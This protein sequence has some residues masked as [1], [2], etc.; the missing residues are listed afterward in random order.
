[1]SRRWLEVGVILPLLGLL[2]LIARAELQLRSGVSF[3]VPIEGYDPRD[4]LH[5][6]FLQYRFSFDW[7]G[8]NRCGRLSGGVPVEVDPA[9]CICLS[10]GT[11]AGH[12]PARQ[13][14][15][16]EVARCD[17]WLRGSALAPPLKYFVPERRALELEEA[18]RGRAAALDVTCGPDGQPAIGEL[19]LDG[20]PWRDV[21]GAR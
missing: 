4:L 3:R 2:V 18:L 1:M 11:G 6:H 20:R 14:P 8:E 7:Q 9:C 19:F 12:A 15:C 13:L 16:V 21:I 5:G 17:G 10:A